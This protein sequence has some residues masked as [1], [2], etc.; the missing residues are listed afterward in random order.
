MLQM[1]HPGYL[2][3]PGDMFSVDPERVMYATGA[4]KF[5][6]DSPDSYGGQG[7]NA[8]E[9]EETDAV[10]E[11]VSEDGAAQEAVTESTE[12]E[13][14]TDATPKQH[15]EALKVLLTE[16]KDILADPKEKSKMSGK[17]KQAMRAFARKVRTTMSRIRGG[18]TVKTDEGE[19]LVS[20]TVADLQATLETLTGVESTSSA[21]VASGGDAP[22]STSADAASEE[23]ISPSRDAAI[24]R[25]ALDQAS[26]VTETQDASK[27]Y[28]TPW[29]PREY[30]SAF[31]FIPRY[32][33]V[34]Q[35]ICSAVYL[36]HPVARPGLAEV[37]SPYGETTYQLA[38]NWYLR[39]R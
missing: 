3:N 11:V 24:L 37:P 38:H 10:E 22:T 1:L 32:L 33:E 15:R 9:N 23:S 5:K 35:R 7:Q 2:L 4:R 27:P 19:A 12:A 26:E 13:E 31:A 20:D 16:A 36:R 25:R 18:E 6:K 8:A 39:R 28:A 14:V 21:N 17:Q 30:M 29:R 34:S